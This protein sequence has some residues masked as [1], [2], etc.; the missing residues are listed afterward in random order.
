MDSSISKSLNEDTHNKLS[1]DSFNDNNDS[2]GQCTEVSELLGETRES[3]LNSSELTNGEV[4]A[5][6]YCHSGTTAL[7][8]EYGCNNLGSQQ[9]GESAHVQKSTGAHYSVPRD[10]ATLQDDSIEKDVVGQQ[11]TESCGHIAT[12]VTAIARYRFNPLTDKY[13]EI[14]PAVTKVNFNASQSSSS[15]TSS[16]P[17]CS[18]SVANSPQSEKS[19][20]I[21]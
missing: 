12:R 9:E 4:N 5:S 6:T 1:L 7:N 10:A 16:S 21:Y 18:S 17:V 13:E 8:I 20:S 19:E 11:S 2:I 14:I 3:V 15:S